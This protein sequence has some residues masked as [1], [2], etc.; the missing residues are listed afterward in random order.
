MSAR[1]ASESSLAGPRRR[2]R[3]VGQPA[4]GREGLRGH[5]RGRG[6]GRRGH[7]QGQPVQALHVQGRAGRRGHGA[8]AGPGAGE[9]ARLR[10]LDARRPGPPEGRGA[11]GLRAAAGRPDARPALAELHA[12]RGAAGRQGLHGPADAAVRRA[13]RLDRRGP[14][15]GPAG[16]RCRPS[17]CSTRCSRAPA[18]RCWASCGQRRAQRRADRRLAG[19]TC[20]KG[21][22]SRIGAM[23]ALNPSP[24]R[25]SPVRRFRP[26]GRGGATCWPPAPTGSTST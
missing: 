22:A 13:G 26:P 6:G 15:R 23:P 9:L 8:G 14:G 10:S 5:D 3:G 25:P 21:L 19:A 2:H 12:A 4:A 20:F 18:T 24:H 1:P 7:R 16:R 17:W 11:L